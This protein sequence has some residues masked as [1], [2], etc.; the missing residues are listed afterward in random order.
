[1]SFK[2]TAT[3]INAN[4]KNIRYGLTSDDDSSLK[5]NDG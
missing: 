5:M 4:K 2:P 3:K 1:M